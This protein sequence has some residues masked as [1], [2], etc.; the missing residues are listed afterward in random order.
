MGLLLVPGYQSTPFLLHILAK[1][2]HYIYYLIKTIPFQCSQYRA[3]TI[4]SWGVGCTVAQ[5]VT[6]IM[7]TGSD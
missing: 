7:K 3:V 1:V 6:S 4:D 5:G 2:I